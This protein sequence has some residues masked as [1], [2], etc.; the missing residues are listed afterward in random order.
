[1]ISTLR[2]T[3]RWETPESDS[4]SPRFVSDAINSAQQ[5]PVHWLDASPCIIPVTNQ[6]S[7]EALEPVG[8]LARSLREIFG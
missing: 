1:M 2:K 7:I 4:E 3:S 5:I 8:S 6:N